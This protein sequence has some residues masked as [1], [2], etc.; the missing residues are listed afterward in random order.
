VTS[1]PW[2]QRALPQRVVHGIS[3]ESD[4]YTV[5]IVREPEVI[6]LDP[7]PAGLPTGHPEF[8]DATHVIPR[9]VVVEFPN[10]RSVGAFGA[11]IGPNNEL[12]G[13]LS[14][15]FVNDPR[16]HPIFRRLLLP[17]IT[18][19]PDAVAV[20]ASRGMDNYYHFLLEILPRLALLR[21]CS[22]VPEPDRFL[23]DCSHS[24]Q[25]ELLLAAGIDETRVI[26]P[27]THPHISAANLI[28][29]SLPGPR[30]LTPPWVVEYVRGLIPAGVTSER[31]RIYISRGRVRNT[32]RVH[33]EAALERALAEVG[34]ITVRPENLRVSEQAKAFHAAEVIVAPH[35]AGLANLVFCQPGTAVVELFSASYVSPVFW[36]LASIVPG[37]RYTYIVGDGSRTDGSESGSIA[38][39]VRVDTSTVLRVVDAATS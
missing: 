20:L 32:R 30:T 38:A 13:E 19:V 3:L 7:P 5:R 37:L 11:I 2:G 16:M 15:G 39:D 14:P 21:A 31:T 9:R 18:R 28:V 25:R 6:H 36:R 29:P 23:V 22:D 35:G 33:D 8:K 10:G 17:P 12:I 27:R 4:T 34:F 24:F 1:R 26:Q